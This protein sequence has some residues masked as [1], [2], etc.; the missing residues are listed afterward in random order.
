M[1]SEYHLV[2]LPVLLEM[3]QVDM[4]VW[5]HFWSSLL[6]L[7]SRLRLLFL[8]FHGLTL[9]SS[10]YRIVFDNLEAF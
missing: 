9:L 5:L 1:Y 4:L 8:T 7:L 3:R 6:W 10:L 2:L